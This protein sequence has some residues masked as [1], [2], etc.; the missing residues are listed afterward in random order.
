MKNRVDALIEA[1]QKNLE[2]IQNGDAAGS[3]S[4]T[5]QAVQ[6]DAQT[7]DSLIDKLSDNDKAT[8]KPNFDYMRQSL[9]KTISF[10][11][12]AKQEQERE[13]ED[14]NQKSQGHKAYIK[15]MGQR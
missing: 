5:V 13:V 12:Q 2:R 6:K 3:I 14:L 7:L 15:T 11:Q 1:V 8:I 10:M 9:A 4:D